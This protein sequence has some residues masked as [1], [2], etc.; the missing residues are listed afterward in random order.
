MG[1]IEN[2]L[3]AVTEVEQR[4]KIE[5]AAAG[6]ERDRMIRDAIKK[7]EDDLK[8]AKEDQKRLSGAHYR[9]AVSETKKEA[10]KIK[11]DSLKEIK[12]HGTSI[13]KK[14]KSVIKEVVDMIT[15]QNPTLTN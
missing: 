14:R 3:K 1:E 4:R 7:A 15:A 13:T 2:V 5:M 11:L 10:E 12:K 9:K 6:K 8:K